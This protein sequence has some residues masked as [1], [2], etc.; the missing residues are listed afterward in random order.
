VP[1]SERDAGTGVAVRIVGR[2]LGA[3]REARASDVR[4]G[5]GYTAVLLDDGRAGVAFTFR[6]LAP[7]GCCAFGGVGS[8]RGRPAADLLVLLESRDVIQAGVGLACAN[9]LTCRAEA[10]YLEGDVLDHLELRS[11]DRVGM[12]GHFGPL[13]EPILARA[14]SLTVF[15]R[16]DRARGLVRPQE[17]AESTLPCCQVALITATCVVNHTIDALLKAARGCRE[18]VLLGASTPMMPEVFDGAPVT[19]LS[20]IVVREPGEVLRV[21][22]EGGGAR[23]FGPYV[24]KVTLQGVN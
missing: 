7:G 12:V 2:L 8:L 21:I 5:L 9:A 17:E 4:I 10:A 1:S 24:R 23:E 18:V 16:V 22:S 6:D 15:E 14:R 20:G 13:V 3:A 19:L 11:D